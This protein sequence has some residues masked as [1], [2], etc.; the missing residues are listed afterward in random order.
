MMRFTSRSCVCMISACL[1]VGCIYSDLPTPP[2]SPPPPAQPQPQSLSI[3]K[4]EPDAE[5]YKGILKGLGIEPV[6]FRCTGEGGPLAYKVEIEE[7]GGSGQKSEGSFG[8]IDEDST[9]SFV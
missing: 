4:A 7:A 1:L 3:R 5:V 9:V 2:V 8:Q 6:T